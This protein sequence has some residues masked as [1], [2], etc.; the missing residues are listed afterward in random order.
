MR[1][2]R[3]RQVLAL[4]GTTLLGSGCVGLLDSDNEEN[5][6]NS[7]ENS[8]HG[9]PPDVD[10]SAPVLFPGGED[11]ITIEARDIE[12]FQWASDLIEGDRPFTF[13]QDGVSPEADAIDGSNPARY[14]WGEP[15]AVQAEAS[16]Q[17]DDDA[18]A[19][20]YSYRARLFAAGDYEQS[21][22]T[23][24]FPIIVLEQ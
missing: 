18:P 15:T 24:E 7:D 13:T 2:M 5:T 12:R 6:N 1:S 14:V 21:G 11:T 8:T 19:G 20:R 4:C 17:I 23:V 10:A 9:W 3:R 22:V 16:I